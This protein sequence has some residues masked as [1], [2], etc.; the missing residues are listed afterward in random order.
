MPCRPGHKIGNC[1]RTEVASLVKFTL[2]G[3]KVG[4]DCPWSP[5]AEA[6]KKHRES[7]VRWP[8]QQQMTI[9]IAG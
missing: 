8:T 7:L 4:C 9:R 2:R 3:N 1:I 6:A 5:D